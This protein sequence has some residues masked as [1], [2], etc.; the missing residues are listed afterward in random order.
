M[1]LGGGP[2]PVVLGETHFGDAAATDAKNSLD[3]A[4]GIAQLRSTSNPALPANFAGVTLTEGVHNASGAMGFTAGT[5]LTL[6]GDEDAVFIIQVGGALSVGA[7]AQ[8]TLVGG[9]DACNVFW[10][11]NGATTLGAGAKFAGT[12]MGTAAIS[13]GA[14]ARVDGR[15]LARAGAITLDSNAI[16]TACAV[17]EVVV[18][19]PGPQGETGADGADGTDG[20]DGATGPTGPTGPTGLTGAD[21]VQGLTGADGSAGVDGAAG[22]DGEDGLNGLAGTDRAAGDDGITGAA[23]ADGED[24]LNGLAGTDGAAGVDGIGE[25]TVP[26]ARTA[27]TALRERTVPRDRPA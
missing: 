16:R 20:A 10:T 12:V 8:V 19:P 4:Y 26:M 1:P 6:D 3:A 21:G 24:G 22:A 23:G 5:T 7:L 18:G 27:S 9:A 25:L 2:A 17:P 11:V 14:G 13:V 15:L